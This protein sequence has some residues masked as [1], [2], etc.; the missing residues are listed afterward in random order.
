M[1]LAAMESFSPAA[2][3]A[4]KVLVLGIDLQNDFMEGGSLPVPGSINDI[5]RFTRFIYTN[6]HAITQIVCSLDTHSFHQIFH[7]IWWINEKGEHPAPYTIITYN[8]VTSGAWKPVYGKPAN[9][10][11]YLN[12]LEARGKKKLCIWP[13]H[14][15]EGSDGARL[16]GQFTR[17]MY[18]HSATRKSIPAMIRKGTDTYSEMY[19]I[20]RPEYDTKN[21]VNMPVLNLLERFD[22]IFIAGQAKSHCC[23]ESV[24]QILE[25]FVGRPEITQR[26][27]FLEDCSSSIPGFEKD[28][29]NEF[30][31]FKKQYGIHILKSTDIIL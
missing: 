24:K 29:D 12:E 31:T 7:P 27:T 19:G 9:S 18:F 23:L 17:M 28:T 30:E 21:F 20:I 2:N 25:F 26:I 15:L 1:K 16:E 11:K 3:D 13:Y 14:C 10:I 4:E 6:L 22:K 8:D 5:E